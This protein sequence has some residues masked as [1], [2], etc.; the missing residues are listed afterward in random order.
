[1]K[2]LPCLMS[3]CVH[4]CN[5]SFNPSFSCHDSKIVDSW[6][7]CPAWIAFAGVLVKR[8]VCLCNCYLCVIYWASWSLMNC[9]HSLHEMG[10]ICL[11]F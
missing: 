7:T 9:L 2:M 8:L 6:C 10:R 5:F 11:K 1:M 3:V 4:C